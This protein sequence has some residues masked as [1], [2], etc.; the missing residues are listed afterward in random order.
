MTRYRRM[1][2]FSFSACCLDLPVGRTLKPMMMASEALANVTSVS[3]MPPTAECTMLM[4]T[5]D[6]SIFSNASRS[7]SMEPCTSAFT[8]RLRSVCLPS[9]MRLN[10]S[11]R[12][13]WDFVSCSA[14]RA[15]SA[16]SSA[17]LRASRSSA[18]TRNSSPAVGTL[19]KPRISTGSAGPA[20]STWRPRGS[21]RID[22]RIARRTCQPPRRRPDGACRACTSTVATGPRPLSR[23][24]SMTKPEA[25]ASGLALSSSTSACRRIVSSTSVDVQAL[26]GRHLHEHVRAAPLLGDDAVLGEFL[27]HA[28]GVRAGLVDLVHGHHDGD[29]G[30]LRVVE[31]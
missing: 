8:M 1:S 25:S 9:S 23:F 29:L 30:G 18:N 14:K 10:R 3:V 28:V 20:A 31:L 4:R 15:R 21:T 17:S 27:A 24:A 6:W 26:L 22:I 13:I 11:S 7:A 19:D 12:L 2:T 5:S 16:R